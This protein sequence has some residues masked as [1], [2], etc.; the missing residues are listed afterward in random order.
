MKKYLLLTA[1]VVH[2]AYPVL[3][4]MP[5]PMDASA[6]EYAVYSAVIANMFAGDGIR[7]DS[8][9]K[10]QLVIQDATA[11]EF[12]RDTLKDDEPY[13]REMFP[14]LAEGVAED[15]NVRNIKPSRL[16]DSFKLNL[17]H[18]MLKKPEL[19]KIFNGGG[20]WEEFYKRYPG[21]SGFIILSRVGFNA[22]MNQ[23]LVY[24]HH[25]CGGLC[26][27]GHYVLL[28]K[29]GNDWRAIKKNMV[30]IS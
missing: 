28:E 12:I 3:Q 19:D 7:V 8:T 24:I 1:I 4:A 11:T 10:I 2:L 27:T 22:V 6:E 26:G 17:K 29:S 15:Y 23:A 20:G 30:W 16:K 21:S 25:G 5:S 18:V 14:M 13:F 9:S